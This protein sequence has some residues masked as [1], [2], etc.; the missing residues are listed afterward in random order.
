MSDYRKLRKSERQRAIDAGIIRTV[1]KETGFTP[2]TVSRT[3]AGKFRLTNKAIVEA[4]N[5]FLDA[6]GI[7]RSAA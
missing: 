3:F 4:L 7:E 6:V 5:R 1:A 2:A